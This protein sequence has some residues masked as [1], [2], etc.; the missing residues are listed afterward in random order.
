MDEKKINKLKNEINKARGEWWDKMFEGTTVK[1]AVFKHLNS[2]FD[3][4]VTNGVGLRI[5]NWDGLKLYQTNGYQGEIVKQLVRKVEDAGREWIN[6]ITTEAVQAHLKTL[7]KDKLLKELIEKVRHD[8]G[9]QLRR[10]GSEKVGELVSKFVQDLMVEH[11]E[12]FLK[13]AS[14]AACE[15]LAK[16]NIDERGGM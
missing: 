13:A 7:D 16:D 12:E 15:E 6:E 9:Y 4:I 2:Y 8:V 1:K 14:V 3:K 11:H 5:D 10:V